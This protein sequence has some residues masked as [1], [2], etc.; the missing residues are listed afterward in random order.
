MKLLPVFLCLFVGSCHSD[1]ETKLDV[2]PVLIA[3]TETPTRVV[4]NK[5]YI[6]MVGVNL[7]HPYGGNQTLKEIS[8]ERIRFYG[9]SLPNTYPQRERLGNNVIM[10]IREVDKDK[11]WVRVR[12]VL[13][14]L[15]M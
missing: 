9:W 12:F 7:L 4:L 10:H 2:N 14:A 5:D 3:N 1:M 6:W 11:K 8:D 13:G 15:I